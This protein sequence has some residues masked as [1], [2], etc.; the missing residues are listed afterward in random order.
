MTLYQCKAV[1]ARQHILTAQSVIQ[2]TP[3][4]AATLDAESLSKWK[5]TLQRNAQRD[6]L[7][8]LPDGKVFFSLWEEKEE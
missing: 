5:D 4:V 2:I 8:S 6:L 3:N 1:L 7:E